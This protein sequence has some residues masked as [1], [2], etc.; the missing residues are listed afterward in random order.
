MPPSVLAEPAA[1][2]TQH[3]DNHRTGANL[4]ETVLHTG[5]V[6]VATFGR[7]GAMAVDGH[8]Y[9]QPLYAPSID[10]PGHG[11][12]DVLYVATMN[13]TVF[14]FDAQTFATLWTTPLGHAVALPNND[15]GGGPNYRD[16]QVQV[17]IISTPVISIAHRAIYLVTFSHT[18]GEFIHELHALDLA[19]G[20]EKFGGPRR[21][22]A[23]VAGTG[24]GSAN[25]TVTFAS[26]LENQ[27][28]ALL[29]SNN[30]VYVAF[31]SYGDFGD[32]HGWVVGYDAATLQPLPHPANLTPNAIAGGIWQAGQGPAADAHGN[33]YLVSGNGN[34]N[35]RSLA[36]K[37][38]LVETAIGSPAVANVDDAQ[39]ALAWTGNEALQRL[40][41]AV[42]TDARQFTGKVTLTDTSLDNPAL[43]HGHGRLFLAWT[44]PDPEQH[45]NVMSSA[46]LQ[47]FTNKVV[48]NETSPFGPA[49]AFGNGRVY[50]AWIGR[51]ALQRLNV[52]SSVDG[53]NWEHKVTL[54]DEGAAAPALQFANGTLYLAWIGTDVN[55]RLNIMESADGVTFTNKVTLAHTSDSSPSLATHHGINLAWTG[56]G[57]QRPLMIVSG[58][59]TNTLGTTET[60][61]DNPRADTAAF[62]PALVT[63]TGKLYIA[64]AGN[65]PLRRLNVAEVSD[66]PSLGDCFV[67]LSPDLAILD[68]FTPWNTHELNNIDNDLGSGGLLLL[69]NTNVMA[70]G[71]KEG[72]LYLIDRDH[73]GRLCS[74]CSAATGETRIVDAFQATAARN[75]P[76]A[77]EPAD[78]ADGF[79]HIHGSPVFWNSPT[80]GPVVYV[81]GEAD[82]LRA[83]AF[84]GHAF[85]HHPVD[86]SARNIHTP[87][88]S[89]PG[90]MLSLSAHGS[91]AG[92]GI[93]WTVHPTKDDA[94]RGAVAGTV[95]AFDADD[96]KRRL[97]HS[98]EAAGA[99]DALGMLAKF[100]PPTVANGRVYMATFSHQIVVYG[101][102]S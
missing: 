38:I 75:D 42:S 28:P 32:Y 23:T 88:R 83:Y 58:A 35:S 90:A 36:G 98:D 94:N 93:L 25:G 87:N 4:H 2:L 65:E 12:R 31:A 40:N 41:V 99:R 39:I 53:V 55:R 76:H 96:L 37:S 92:T 47:N 72:K 63:F 6:R 44:G 16:I 19:T 67:K 11:A 77:P 26:H 79:H 56:I 82:W 30:R 24:A 22:A 66:V 49:L 43:C 71:G 73:L 62:G 21:I 17:G 51:E 29:L 74:T 95:S 3:N 70:G 18:N 27:R 91:T 81:W 78:E 60:Y 64:W 15:I 8:V 20:H 10:L 46:D 84:N 97:W 14:A 85:V 13:N 52:M 59:A 33:V 34:Y 5:N 68:W 9:A 54:A 48:L 80:R 89:M 50:L 101:L 61:S 57:G 7:I 69:P 45:V 86:I 102:L 100:T 1:V